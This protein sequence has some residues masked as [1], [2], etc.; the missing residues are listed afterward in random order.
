MRGDRTSTPR[1]ALARLVW[2][3]KRVVRPL[4]EVTRPPSD[5]VA[6][7]NVPVTIRDGVT[8]RVNVFRPPTDEPVPVIMS[9]HPYGKDRIPINGRK[10][11]GLNIQYRMLPQPH[12]LTISA[13]TGWEAPDP[14]VWVPRGYAVVNADLRG[15]G[16]SEGVGRLL[17][18]EEAQDYAELIEWAARQAWCNG[19]VGLDGVSY[20]AISQYKVAAVHPEHLAAICPWEGFSDLYRDWVYPGGVREN[21]FSL[22]WGKMTGRSARVDVDLSKELEAHTERD[23]FYEERTPDL[24]A[25]SVPM[26]VCGSFSDHSLHTRGSFELFRQASSSQK[27]LYTHRSGKWS[28][29]YG[30]DATETRAAFFDHFLRGIENGWDRRPPVRL[31]IHERGPDPAE[32]CHEA[33]WPP[34]DLTW[35]E[36]YLSPKGL[37]DEPG[38]ASTV[39][40][41]NNGPGV[42]FEWELPA[43]LDVIGPMALRLHLSATGDDDP[44]VFV[45]VNKVRGGSVVPFEGSLGFD[46]DAVTTGWQRP[47]FRELDEALS[48]P[49]RPV[50][51]FRSPEPLRPAEI[52]PVDVELREQATRF[53]AGDTLRLEV[54]GHWHFPRNPVTGQFPCGYRSSKRG[55][56]VIHMGTEHQSALLLGHRPPGAATASR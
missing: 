34:P 18:D 27:W 47:A 25:I 45:A 35:S 16:K 9:A 50:H 20:L 10:G 13:W 39:S 33:A 3:A 38:P 40:Y 42:A 24:P 44:R 2:R 6:E 5:V 55:S 46:R 4:V 36:R 41:E 56:C 11:K 14:A 21:G 29:Y 52:V 48:A 37:V 22:L 54:R 51:T 19:R 26:L 1:G 17:S 53:R 49:H 31:A 43:D 8:L 12:P 7:W 23:G 32:V 28:A 15:G 30:A